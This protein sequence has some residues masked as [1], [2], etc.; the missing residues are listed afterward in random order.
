MNDSTVVKEYVFIQPDIH[1]KENLLDD[2][3]KD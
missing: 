1:E 3:V 2:I